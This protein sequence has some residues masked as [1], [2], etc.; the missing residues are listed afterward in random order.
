MTVIPVKIRMAS[1]GS[2]FGSR[3]P[4]VGLATV[5]A[6]CGGCIWMREDNRRRDL[7]VDP[8]AAALADSA[9]YRDT[10]GSLTYFD[11]LRPM[12]VRGYGLVVGLGRNGSRDCPRQIY[13]RLVESL[14]K[15]QRVTSS[16]VGVTTMTPEELI[17]SLDSAVVIVEGDIPPG[18]MEGDAF[19]VAVTAVPGTET[20]S[21]R[22]GRLIASDLH[23]FRPVSDA[24]SITGKVLARSAGPVFVNPFM[25]ERAATEA[26]PLFGIVLGGGRTSEARRLRMVLL[27]PS[28]ARAQQI[29]DRINAF[30]PAGRRVA[31][32]LSPS[33]VQMRVP[34]EF[35]G[36]TGHFLALV[37]AIYL[38]HDPRFE[39][40]RARM[41]ADEIVRPGAP[42]GLIASAFEGLGRAA[43]PALNDLYAHTNDDVSFHAAAAGLRLGDHV[44]EDTVALHARDPNCRHRF[45]AVRAL[46]EAKGMAGAAMTLRQLLYDDD[47]RIRTSAYEG[48]ARR[49][50]SI[51]QTRSIDGDNFT[52]DLV[53]TRGSP[54]IYA[55]RSGERRIAL[56]GDG[57]QCRPPAFYRAPDGSLT[58]TAQ[59]DDAQ[60]TLM[61]VVVG[62]GAASEP[63]TA[64]L[65]VASLIRLL[66]SR[67][68]VD[69]E[70]T[71]TGLGLDYGTVVHALYRLAQDGT[72]DADFIL[73]EPNVADLFG[74]P[75]VSG[76]PESEM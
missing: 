8:M 19:D 28:Y 60:L 17:N 7:G 66:G 74:P 13:D 57:L 5:L 51:V 18:A 35:R 48:L 34:D 26:D 63:I 15:Q 4:V 33:F 44:G 64:S 29:Q 37:R 21:L 54:F 70:G 52:L 59:P 69:H 20:R 40:S 42:L 56:F 71:V 50:D 39:A 76:R 25:G 32:A 72:I 30:F 68:D 58:V 55:R 22:G 46:A 12:R 75:P 9:A 67:A 10:I 3:R 23:V 6:L 27:Q 24:V 61:R 45:A 11:G 43:L 65:D 1:V 73:E 47:V 49:G 2:T 38:V 41:L 53:P 16:V 62:T 31:D 14:Y 36:D